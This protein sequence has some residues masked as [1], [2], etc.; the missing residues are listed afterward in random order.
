MNEVP[1][2]AYAD[3]YDYWFLANKQVLDSEVKL[4]AHAL[5]E[6]PG[7]CLS[8]GCGSGLFETCLARDY[9]LH[10]KEGVEPS[11]GMRSIA[12]KRGLDVQ[13]ASAE[14]MTLHEATYDTIIFNGCSSY[15][16][17]P[18]AAFEKARN[19]LKSGSRLL[20]LDVPKES[21]YGLLYNF[22]SETGGWTHP[23][24]KGVTPEQI[25][26]LEFVKVARWTTTPDKIKQLEALGFQS[27]TT[28]QTLVRHPLYTNDEVEEPIPGFDRGSYVCI[29]AVR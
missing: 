18:A 21:A 3:Q 19:A 5:G 11:D 24:L 20:V 7:R 2:D 28:A 6:N 26:P 29:T 4:L 23:A 13:A 1:F 16:A 10:I 25:Y 12:I 27:I 17:D 8:V 22:G 15:L 9:D 14:T